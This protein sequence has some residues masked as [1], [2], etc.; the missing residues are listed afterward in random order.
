MYRL[1]YVSPSAH[2]RDKTPASSS[3]WRVKFDLP[4][5]AFSDRAS[6]VIT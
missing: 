5:L 6:P 4:W 1:W 2:T 3:S